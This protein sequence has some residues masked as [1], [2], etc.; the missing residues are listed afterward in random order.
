M[1][2]NSENGITA[3]PEDSF[4]FVIMRPEAQYANK[5][6]EY[7]AEQVTKIFPS[8]QVTVFIKRKNLKENLRR[9][10]PK[11]IPVALEDSTRALR[12]A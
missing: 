1:P 7:T 6:I 8:V 3:M 10:T 11:D 2:P 12:E 5:A 4:P 9:E